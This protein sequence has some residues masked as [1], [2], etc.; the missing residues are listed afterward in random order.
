M[1]PYATEVVTEMLLHDLSGST[2]QRLS[3][4]RDGRL[5]GSGLVHAVPD[6]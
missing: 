1:Y 6:A 5:D 4:R 3:R 2:R